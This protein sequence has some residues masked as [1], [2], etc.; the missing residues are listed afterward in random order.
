[1]SEKLSSALDLLNA[2]LEGIIA[3]TTL[4]GGLL[5]VFCDL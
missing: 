3:L 5:V 4:R 2:N 1:M